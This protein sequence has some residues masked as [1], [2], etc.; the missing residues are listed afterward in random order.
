MAITV[1]LYAGRS[2]WPLEATEIDLVH[3]KVAPTELE[4]SGGKTDRVTARIRLE[5][6]LTEE[7]RQR[8]FVIA[9]R[10]PVHRLL[11]PVIHFEEYLEP[12]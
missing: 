5:G 8:L 7:Q 9:G 12:E 2:R 3:E 6:P 11:A 10:C 1:R 4:L